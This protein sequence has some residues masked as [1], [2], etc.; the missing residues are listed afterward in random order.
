MN[1]KDYY[2]ILGID[3]KSS[4]KEIKSAYHKLAVKWHPD[5]WVGKSE[6]EKKI[7]EEKMKEVNQAYEVLSNSEK[8]QN[9]DQYGSTEGFAQGGH[10]GGGFGREES[11]FKDIFETF[12]GGAADYAGQGKYSEDRARPQAGNDV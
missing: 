7:A 12:F 9:Y 4:E 10:P 2:D 11:F 3:R 1:K 5:K 8:R 6:A